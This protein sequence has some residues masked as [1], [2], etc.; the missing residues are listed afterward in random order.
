MEEVLK[1]HRLQGKLQDSLKSERI[2][3][4]SIEEN[5]IVLGTEDG[6]VHLMSLNGDILRSFKA[7]DRAVND[8]SVDNAGTAIAR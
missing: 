4:M 3:A 2:T 5:S 7:H 1:Y 8:I 6:F